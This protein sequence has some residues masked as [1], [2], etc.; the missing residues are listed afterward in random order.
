M[1]K[2]MQLS[3]WCW[4]KASIRYIIVQKFLLHT[5]RLSWLFFNFQSTCKLNLLKFSLSQHFH[6]FSTLIFFQVFMCCNGPMVWWTISLCSFFSNW[7][8]LLY[9]LWLSVSIAVNKNLI[10][11]IDVLNGFPKYNSKSKNKMQK[12]L[13]M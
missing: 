3:D 11:F 10:A 2:F 12:Q 9:K 13:S 7:R 1:K 4:K 6:K 5:F 8:T